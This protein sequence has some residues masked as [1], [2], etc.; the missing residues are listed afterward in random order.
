[1]SR[2]S[3]VEVV[4]FSFTVR[5]FGR[6][7]DSAQAVYS[8]GYKPNASLELTKFAAVIRTD[9]GVQGAHVAQRGGTRA[10][11]AQTLSL[12]PNLLGRDPDQRE[13]L[14]SPLLN[15]RALSREPERDRKGADG[16]LGQMAAVAI[17]QA[18]IA[19]A[20]KIR[21]VRRETRWR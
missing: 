13:L 9:D 19:S 21:S 20:R 3:E 14:A 18:C 6:S 5:D 17:C 10:T 4:E 12:A 8:I 11:M 1:M 7:A 2:I 16:G 15:S